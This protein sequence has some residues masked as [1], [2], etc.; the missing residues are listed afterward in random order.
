VNG[1]INHNINNYK[2]KYY[3]NLSI[4]GIILSVSLL[5]FAFLFYVLL[6][7]FAHFNSLIRSILFYSY[8]LL[9]GFVFIRWIGNPIIRVFIS[10]LQISNEKAAVNIGGTFPQVRD[11]LLNIIQLYR[12][13]SNSSDL[14]AASIDQKSREIGDVNFSRAVQFKE[15]KKYLTYLVVPFILVIFLS[16]VSPKVIREGTT[17]LVKHNEDFSPVIPFTFI[18]ENSDL[19]AYKNENYEVKLSLQGDYMPDNVY[20]VSNERKIKLLNVQNSG[21]SYTFQKVSHDIPFQFEA[22]GYRSSNHKIRVVERPN[23]KNFNVKLVYPTYLNKTDEQIINTGNFK[24]PEGTQATWMFNTIETDSILISFQDLPDPVKLEHPD[25]QLFSSTRQFKSSVEYELR[26][27]NRYSANKEQIRYRVDVI[28]DQ[29]PRINL[30]QFRDTVLYEFLILGGN[31]NDDYGFRDLSLNYRIKSSATENQNDFQRIRFPVDY[32]KSSQSFYYNW[33][34]SSYNLNKGNQVEYFLEV[35]DNDAINGSKVTRTATYLFR[36]PDR[37]EIKKEL[38]NSSQNTENQIDK[39]LQ[40][41]QE[42]N[43]KLEDIEERLKGKKEMDWQ[44][45]MHIQELIEEKKQLESEVEKLKELYKAE[46]LKRERFTEQDQRLL[47]KAEQLQKLMDELLDEE[48]KKLYEELQKLL[49]EQLDLNKFREQLDKIDI[50]EGNLEKELERALELYKRMK[51]D[52]KL[53][54]V[55]EVIQNLE[56]EQSEISDETGD[57]NKDLA[58]ISQ[59]QDSIQQDFKDIQKSMEELLDLNQDLKHSNRVE[60]TSQEEKGIQEEMD[61]ASEELDKGKRKNAQKAQK[62]A[63]GQ[64]NTLGKKMEQMMSQNEMMTLQ[65]NLDDLRDILD[66]LVKLS[67]DQEE[68]MDNLKS[69]KQSDP[70]F[71]E[72]SQEQLDLKDDAKIVEDSLLA[73]ASR[74]MQI[75]SFVTREVGDMNRY[76]DESLEALKER[77]KNESIGKQQFSMTSMNN[78]AIMLDDVLTQMQQQMADAMGMP[79]KD[80]QGNKKSQTLS[81]LQKQLSEQIKQLKGS[82]KQGRQLSEELSRLAAEQ[83]RIRNAMEKMNEKSLQSE[84]N[85]EN[86]GEIIEKMEE[87]ELD[88]V[89]KNLTE[90]LIRRQ[91]EILTRLLQAE[92]AM[93]EQD[94]DPEREGE[95]AKSIERIIPEAFDEYLKAKEREVELLKTIPPKLNPFYKNEV[96]E[97]FKRL[98]TT[99]R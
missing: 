13:D 86:L 81:E 84:E 20:I 40:K 34:L 45:E 50:D 65:E 73:L 19:I 4:R 85:G 26:L 7:Y 59:Q 8:L 63:A 11:K 18:L 93:R 62:S 75:S 17:R 99:I 94:M 5:V 88:L 48:T 74:V 89:N 60:D 61:N 23:I 70:R 58:T 35:R 42:L 97:Y 47:E 72:L 87:T 1:N 2:R 6:E 27:Y 52:I 33:E 24:V 82:G 32:S 51:F 25:D 83:E 64:M 30:N 12:F 29:F 28:P 36:I 57:K 38:E 68:L 71:I 49:E 46:N 56:E 9:L 76:I 44:D 91:E 14:V 79:S 31:I 39:S 21:Y 3:L 92:D 90:E 37:D 54:E 53:E 55:L 69:I 10:D 67:F 15:N 43:E 41:A 95:T 96:N 22:A 98:E 16:A 77:N 78:L 66:N 80:K